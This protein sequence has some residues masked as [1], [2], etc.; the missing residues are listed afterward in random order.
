[1]NIAVCLHAHFRE[2]Y[3]HLHAGANQQIPTMCASTSSM[4]ITMTSDTTT[5]DSKVVVWMG[6]AILF[7]IVAMLLAVTSIALGIIVHRTRRVVISKPRTNLTTK[8]GA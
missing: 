2:Y 8:K 1:M 6:M 7:L 5:M 3:T 4:G